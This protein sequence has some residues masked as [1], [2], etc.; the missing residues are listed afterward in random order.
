MA[1]GFTV[2]TPTG[3]KNALDIRAL[4]RVHRSRRL[5]SSGSITLPLAITNNG[6]PFGA[7]NDG[8]LAPYIEISGTTVSWDRVLTPVETGFVSSDF[9]LLIFK[10]V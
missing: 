9:E 6:I 4:R 10:M 5:S 2:S 8:G 3:L 7:P 1:W